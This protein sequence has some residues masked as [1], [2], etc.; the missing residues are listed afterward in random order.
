MAIPYLIL[1]IDGLF[2]LCLIVWLM[3]CNYLFTQTTIPTHIFVISLMRK[4]CH[5]NVN[6]RGILNYWLID[7]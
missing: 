6:F 1:L 3:W 5:L 4:V 7:I 2:I